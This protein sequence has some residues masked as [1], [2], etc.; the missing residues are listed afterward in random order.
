MAGKMKHTGK[1][2]KS[3]KRIRMKESEQGIVL[4]KNGEI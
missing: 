4:R 3:N 1:S 2:K